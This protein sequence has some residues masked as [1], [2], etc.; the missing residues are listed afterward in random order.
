L[1]VSRV[2]VANRGE[3]AVRVIRACRELGIEAVAVYSTADRD[4]SHVRLADRAV[5]IGPPPATESYLAIPNVIAAATT[6]GCDA[7]H[8]GYGFLSENP[9]FVE[10]CAANDLVFVGPPSSVM[11]VMGDKA[12]AKEAMRAAG[13]PL[14]PG[15]PGRLASVIEAAEAADDAGYP[16]LLK[17]AAGGGGRGM[18]LVAGPAEL[19][20]AFEQATRE[21]SA[22][23]G[24]GGMYLEKAVVGAHHV[25]IQVLCDASGGVLVC[26]ERE[27]SIQRRHQK[28][29]EEAPSPFL[30]EATRSA[31]QD[32]AER[33]CRAIGYVNAGTI[34]FLVGHDRQFY[35]MEMNTRLQVEH[36]VTEAVTGLDLVRGQL[37]VAAGETLPLTG[38]APVTG[39]AIELRVNAEDPRRGF[40]PSAGTVTRF[41]PGL[42]PGVRLDTHV[43]EG[44]RMPPDYDSLLAKLVFWAESREAC[45]ERAIRAVAETEVAGVATTLPLH[46]DILREPRFRSGA[47]STSYLDDA[48]ADLPTLR[49]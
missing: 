14:V 41:R 5:C 36:P 42:G 21:A 35:F 9:A 4:S 12:T 22:A 40:M 27:C 18:R 2:L 16:V 13:L 33:A 25:E 31:M 15:S 46:L 37:R 23:F 8:P 49:A 26:G 3:I 47:Y 10:A 32:A 1:S 48:A 43:A 19:G 29:L 45:I 11:E 44:Y 7:V 30:D 38:R 39:H 20:D 28:L 24:D 17:A 34:E 6:T